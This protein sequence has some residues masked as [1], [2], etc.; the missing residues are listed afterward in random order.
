NYLFLTCYVCFSVCCIFYLF[1]LFISLIYPS[2]LPVSIYFFL[3]TFIVSLCL[4]LSSGVVLILDSASSSDKCIAL[5]EL[6]GPL[7]ISLLI[8][9]NVISCI[10]LSLGEFSITDLYKPIIFVLL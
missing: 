1:F 2:F 8:D 5:R 4:L 10:G 9:T 3:S 7:F 6:N